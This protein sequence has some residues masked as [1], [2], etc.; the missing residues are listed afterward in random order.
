MWSG[1]GPRH[2]DVDH[3]LG[4][5][6]GGVRI[7]S[8][9]GIGVSVLLRGRR[10]HPAPKVTI[11]MDPNVYETFIDTVMDRCHLLRK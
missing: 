1:L 6:K 11:T 2:G 10:S 9:V 7:A 8:I 3:G 5:P 4:A